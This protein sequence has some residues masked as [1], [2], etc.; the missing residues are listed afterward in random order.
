MKV[1]VLSRNPDTYLRETKKD[2]H[3]SKLYFVDEMLN[4]NNQRLILCRN[5]Y[6]NF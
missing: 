3:K 6:R 2:I 5:I 1:K 4:L